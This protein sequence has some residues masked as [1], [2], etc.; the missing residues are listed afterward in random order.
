MA[1]QKKQKQHDAAKRAKAEEM[2]RAGEAPKVIGEALGIKAATVSGWKFDLSKK[3]PSVPR[4]AAPAGQR[5]T[6]APVKPGAKVKAA[7]RSRGAA[8]AAAQAAIGDGAPQ[9]PAAALPAVESVVPVTE[10]APSIE[11]P[12]G[13]RAAPA[14][15]PAPTETARRPSALTL[16]ETPELAKVGAFHRLR[17]IEKE[18]FIPEARLSRIVFVLGLEQIERDRA[19]ALAR[20][21][22]LMGEG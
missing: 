22:A 19:A 6:K 7:P 11:P 13:E 20:A 15:A 5:T 21:A 1:Q 4:L 10:G 14:P 16:R 17:A 9:E 18:T 3:D 2:I 8:Q 12:T